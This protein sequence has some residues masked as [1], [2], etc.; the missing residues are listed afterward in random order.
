MKFLI[1]E[2]I[3]Y[4]D[5]FFAALGEVVRFPGR[6]L[7]PEQLIDADILLVRSITKV[8]QTLLSQANKLKFVGTATIGEDHIDKPL[9][10]E[11]GIAFSSAPG[12]NAVS[13]A[14]YIISALYV[15]AEKYQ[16]NL[17]DK[18][19]GIV[20]VGNIGKTLEHKAK[21]LGFRILLCD[22]V[23]AETENSDE[24]IELDNLLTQSDIVTFHTPLTKA[25][26][27]ST[28]HLLNEHNIGLLKDDVILMNASRGEVI[29][30]SMLLT[31]VKRRSSL[32]I[33]AIKLVLDVWENE[34]NP[35]AA[36][37]EHCDIASAHIAGY[38]LEGKAR[39]T[40]ML[41][42]QV[43]QLLNIETKQQLVNLLPKHDISEL[44]YNQPP[45]SQKAFKAICHLIYDVRRDD[46]LFRQ[47][48]NAKG[49]DWLR[50]NYPQR[51]E[52][53]SVSLKINASDQVFRKYLQ[54]GFD[55]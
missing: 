28:Y 11:K 38:S 43:C 49:F 27:H 53:S 47:Q 22:P 42:A 35:L 10:Q 33:P 36:L 20:G 51:R 24:F 14:E 2:N 54:L 31:E 5:E 18:T 23:R 19:L 39:G 8:N 45:E 32:N 4:A 40:E 16:F 21:A 52:W 50:K 46:A 26:S 13:V 7:K 48:L 30:N 55:V 9:L 34:P 6:E 17:V 1:D 15:L 12:C 29:D 25:G 37:I 41:Y 3:P 44:N